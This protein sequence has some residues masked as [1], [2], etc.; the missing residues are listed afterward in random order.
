MAKKAILLFQVLILCCGVGWCEDVFNVDCFFGWDRCYRPMQ[1]TPVNV[2]ITSTLTDPFQGI[3]TVSAQQDGLNN[4]VIRHEFVLTPN[5]PLEIP[6]VSKFAYGAE[7]CSVRI[8]TPKGKTVWGKSYNLWDDSQNKQIMQSLSENDLMVGLVGHRKYGILKLEKEAACKYGQSVG[9]VFVKD[10]L[11]ANLPWDWTGYGALDVLVL[12]DA[13]LSGCRENQLKAIEQWVRNGGKLLMILSSNPLSEENPLATSLPFEVGDS[14]QYPISPGMGRKLELSLSGTEE[15]VLWPLRKNDSKL[16]DFETFSGQSAFFGVGYCG[17]GRVGVLS[18]D[19][20]TLTGANKH[21]SSEFWIHL[22]SSV[23]VD[24]SI[25]D[26]Q[27]ELPKRSKKS[28][29]YG[30][31]YQYNLDDIQTLSMRDVIPALSEEE[32]E[33]QYGFLTNRYAIGLEQAASNTVM[34][35]LLNIPQMRPLSIWWVILLL[36]FL[37]VLLGPVDYLVLKKI[38]RQPLTWL[39]CGFWIVLFTVGA[40]YGVQALR[41]GELQ[42]RSV[43]VTDTIDAEPAAWSATHAGL[44]APKSDRYQLDGLGD[45]QWWS[46]VSPEQREIYSYGGQKSATRNVYCMQYDGANV[47]YTLPVNIWTMQCL[48]CEEPVNGFPIRATVKRQG[49]R[50]TAEISNMSNMLLDKGYILFD[51]DKVLEF[52]ALEPLASRTIEGMLKTRQIWDHKTGN[53]YNY[54]E[55]IRFRESILNT[56]EAYIAKGSLG[57]TKA[58]GAMIRRGAAVVCAEVNTQEP[59]VGV[60]EKDCHY[61]NRKLYR[62]VVFPDEL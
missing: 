49:G 21:K 61:T 17:F 51:E 37:A 12:Y 62:L 2:R 53:H 58:L 14:T 48:L 23:L 24:A 29:Y 38:D 16:C 59:V 8:T 56:E 1:W 35:Y 5:I 32:M 55:S 11:A 3:L 26:L 18:F 30:Y 28:N 4:L 60:K 20:S 27:P 54:N 15:A 47:P 42:Y 36:V 41:S 57:R 50:V 31:Q 13:D 43:T 40:Y 33:N 25:R 10:K 22:L 7:R 45:Q 9:R 39:T 46:A 52:E 6:L 19:P 34:E 44:F